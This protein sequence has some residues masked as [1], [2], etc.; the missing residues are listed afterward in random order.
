MSA[1]PK[2]PVFLKPFMPAVVAVIGSIPWLRTKASIWAINRAAY[3][4]TLR[5]RALTLLADYTSWRSLTDREYSARHLPPATPEYM[6]GLPSE[7]EVLKLFRRT[8]EKKDTDT[9]VM[10]M[11]FAQW[12]VDSFLA[13]D[14]DD[15]RKNH[16]NHEID[17]CEIYGLTK[18]QTDMLR[19]KHGGRLKVQ[20][21][22]GEEYPP[23]YFE[24]KDGTLVVK[25]EFD[26][27]HDAATMTRI[28]TGVS[29]DRKKKFYAVGLAHGNSTLGNSIM[30]IVWVR[31]HNRLAAM[32]EN[33]HPGWDDERLF[34]T[35]RNIAIVLA[36]KLAVE[37][38]IKH[39]AP[40]DF[41]IKMVDLIADRE[42]WN[43]TNWCAVEFNLLYRWHMLAPETVGAGDT[44][45]TP[46]DFLT[47]NKL[48]ED[49]GIESLIAW[50]SRARAGKIG[51]FNTPTYL[52]IPSP[53]L[54]GFSVESRTIRLSR[55]A[56]LKSYNDYRVAYSMKP[57]T[58]WEQLNKDPKVIEPLKELY[59][60][61]K[62][63]E[64]YVGIFAEDY[65]RELMMGDLLTTMVANDAFTQLLSN[66]LLA[67]NVYNKDTFTQEGLDEIENTKCFADIVKRNAKDPS[68]VYCNFAVR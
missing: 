31:E 11:F 53:A 6:A 36:I 61:I 22:N 26:G 46:A 12:F 15:F 56:Q 48:I 32:L 57:F 47:N 64:W 29:Y 17:L 4:T 3:S 27:L 41:P 7:S 34:E 1:F 40:W 62:N 20:N 9:S 50:C 19:A 42:R 43:R 55:E 16:S 44:A 66:P 45:L 67:A 28:L 14:W 13:T 35:A 37:E 52:M 38:Y 51:L 59:G 63:L 33:K 8:E 25:Q 65:P 23:Y 49:E 24:S 60:D 10:F 21:I 68:R 2:I 58:K 54:N 18:A 5:P 30:N 39:I